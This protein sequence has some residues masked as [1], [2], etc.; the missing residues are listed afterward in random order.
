MN[1]TH[2]FA[3]HLHAQ[4]KR[5]NFLNLHVQLNE[6]KRMGRKLMVEIVETFEFPYLFD[7]CTLQKRILIFTVDKSV[8]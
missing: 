2:F 6:A 4:I 8:H 7:F 5:I 1:L 3:L